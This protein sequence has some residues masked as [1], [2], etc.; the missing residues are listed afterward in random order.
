MYQ[1]HI[2]TNGTKKYKIIG[3]HVGN[4]GDNNF[5]TLI[6]KNMFLDYILPTLEELSLN[7][8]DGESNKKYLKPIED[9]KKDFENDI[10]NR[11]IVK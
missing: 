5:G 3:V 1:E 10:E 4:Q 2:E 8:L 11:K 9:L 6:T 7:H